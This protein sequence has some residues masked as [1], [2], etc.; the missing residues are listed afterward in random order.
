MKTYGSGAGAGPVKTNRLPNPSASSVTLQAVLLRAPL[1]LN[2]LIVGGRSVTV[3][4]AAAEP[5]QPADDIAV[6]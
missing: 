4:V 5:M 1:T 3:T 2:E 6:T